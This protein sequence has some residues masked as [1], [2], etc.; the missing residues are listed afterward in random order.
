MPLCRGILAI[1]NQ[2]WPRKMFSEHVNY[3]EPKYGPAEVR[4]L[5]G[6]TRKDMENWI[7][8]DVYQP[9]IESYTT[10]GGKR[11]YTAEDVAVLSTMKCLSQ[12]GLS[13]RVGVFMGLEVANQV[14]ETIKMDARGDMANKKPGSSENQIFALASSQLDFGKETGVDGYRVATVDWNNITETLRFYCAH[15]IS[16]TMKA[17][18]LLLL[19]TA[20]AGAIDMGS[21]GENA[22]LASLRSELKLKD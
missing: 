21:T 7:K 15:I 10:G 6:C 1:Y 20:Y 16:C 22:Q 3:E 14:R 8:P 2:I 13:P 4:H 11:L 19:M 9:R 12:S 18:E 5:T 17:F